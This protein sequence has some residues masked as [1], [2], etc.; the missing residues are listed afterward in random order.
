MILYFI[1]YTTSV[2]YTTLCLMCFLN[3]FKIVSVCI[4]IQTD[5]QFL[6]FSV[7]FFK[8]ISMLICLKRI[9]YISFKVH[10]SQQHILVQTVLAV[11]SGVGRLW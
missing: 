11:F 5:L 8:P 7:L 2:Y 6:C 9:K 3:F 1:L 10:N 4:Y